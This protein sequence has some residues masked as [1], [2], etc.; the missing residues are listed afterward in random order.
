MKRKVY[1]VSVMFLLLCAV[2]VMAGCSEMV[3]FNPQGP[4]GE[5]ERFLIIAAFLLMLVVVIP[6]IIMSVWFPL[7][8]KASNTKSAYDP[9]WSHSVKIETV[10][11]LV[12]L[13][14][15]LVLSILTWRETHRL[16]PYRRIDPGIKPL[17]IEVVSLDWKWLFIYPEQRIA[18]VN[19]FVLPTKVPL[20][21]RLTSDTVMTSF[22][23]PQL[24]SQIYAMAGMQ[25]RLHL[26]AD[27]PGT[28][29]GQNQQFSGRGYSY[30]TFNAIAT[31]QEA[32]ETWVQKV[33]QSPEKLDYARLEELRL[34]SVKNSV[35]YFSS[36]DPD[37]FDYIIRKYA[38][39]AKSHTVMGENA[40]AA[41]GTPGDLEER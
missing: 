3:L 16:D 7:K 29:A 10:I 34:P 39:M 19:E 32:F 2:T 31:S 28:Y 23:I 13:A 11:W 1:F 15:V 9:K 18:V 30:M 8:Y 26:M 41:H 5:S 40:P 17:N 27:V 4:I 12:P 25:T 38:P 35:A 37:V 24:G 14:I 36:I 21:F 6:V 22:F 20:S 33:K